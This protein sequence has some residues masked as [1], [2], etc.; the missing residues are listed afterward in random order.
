[1]FLIQIRLFALCRNCQINAIPLFNA[2]NGSY[3]LAHLNL[4]TFLRLLNSFLAFQ[5]FCQFGCFFF[6]SLRQFQFLNRCKW[7]KSTVANMV[8][9]LRPFRSFRLFVR[10]SSY[11]VADVIISRSQFCFGNSFVFISMRFIKLVLFLCV[12]HPL[13]V[14][15]FHSVIF[16]LL[17]FLFFSGHKPICINNV[18]FE[19]RRLLLFYVYISHRLRLNMC[20]DV[21]A[22][23]IFNEIHS[24]LTYSNAIHVVDL[25]HN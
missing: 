1:M 25:Y 20:I 21:R 23:I 7:W 12:R 19:C 8:T 14:Y 13:L 16:F 18:R 15:M 3:L 6:P 5:D 10:R 24:F 11:I 22:K 2:R 4:D 17:L 9:S